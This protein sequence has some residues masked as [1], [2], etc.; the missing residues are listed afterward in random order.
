MEENEV[1]A[2]G[3]PVDADFILKQK[4]EETESRVPF[5]YK[6]VDQEIASL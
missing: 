4:W 2:R 5:D 3:F 1:E 6:F